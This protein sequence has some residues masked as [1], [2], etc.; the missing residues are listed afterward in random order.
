M[1]LSEHLFKNMA[2]VLPDYI[3]APPLEKAIDAAKATTNGTRS[4]MHERLVTVS[5]DP[6]TEEDVPTNCE[7]D[8]IEPTN[9]IEDVE[10]VRALERDAADTRGLRRLIALEI[11]RNPEEAS[12]LRDI[13]RDFCSAPL[14]TF[15]DEQILGAQ[16]ETAHT[17]FFT[18]LTSSHRGQG[19]LLKCLQEILKSGVPCG[20]FIRT[21]T[22]KKIAIAKF[23]HYIKECLALW[24]DDE[25]NPPHY[26]HEATIA[27]CFKDAI[28]S[29]LM[30]SMLATK[31]KDSLEVPQATTLGDQEVPVEERV[32]SH[33]STWK[34]SADIFAKSNTRLVVSIAK[35]Y[36]G[37]SLS[38][39]DLIMEGAKGLM[40]AIHR[41]EYR[42]KNKFSTYATWWI[43]Q[44][45]LRG[46]SENYHIVGTKMNAYQV[47][48]KVL[49]HNQKMHHELEREL[50][51]AEIAEST[52]IDVETIQRIIASK[53]QA[54]SL[55]APFERGGDDTG[56]GNLKDPHSH[57]ENPLRQANKKDLRDRLLTG[58]SALPPL[59]RTIINF[60]TGLGARE[61][62]SHVASAPLQFDLDRKMYGVKLTK[63]QIAFLLGTSREWIRQTVD[64]AIEKMQN[65]RNPFT[66]GLQ[67][68][69][70]AEDE[71]NKDW[72]KYREKFGSAV[73]LH[74]FKRQRQQ[75]A[76]IRRDRLIPQTDQETAK[77]IEAVATTIEMD[78]KLLIPL[79][80]IL[81]TRLA[82]ILSAAEIYTVKDLLEC[83]KRQFLEIENLGVKRIV[84]IFTQLRR[85][86]IHHADDTTSEKSVTDAS[87]TK[88]T[89]ADE[90][91]LL[92]FAN[93]I[94]MKEEHGAGVIEFVPISTEAQNEMQQMLKGITEA[95]LAKMHRRIQ[96]SIYWYAKLALRGEN[97]LKAANNDPDED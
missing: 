10:E 39:P 38:F 58:L 96:E 35:K 65:I 74:D 7:E 60:W 49:A 44:C 41:Y 68:F 75:S 26:E 52:G 51:A 85:I 24:E 54:F 88:D 64:R 93:L 25:K 4:A 77:N 86:G 50:T 27:S 45:I 17:K 13:S 32:L 56:I 12:Q 5:T 92:R 90:N 84:E 40:Q 14:L 15:E 73:S 55:D 37:R 94:T 91:L 30:M 95:D 31:C 79:H 66:V 36:R 28:F 80:Q 3:G 6:D 82:N 19:I 20:K 43:R 21:G 61:I 1:P 16:M 70:A 23:K 62:P 81:E 47:E 78:M 69:D 57:Y 67:L 33:F 76:T 59:E 48:S 34:R 83:K 9:M 2:E 72:K 22:T 46:I 53:T 63:N 18:T 29:P 87:P 11:Q 97:S 89:R 71:E 42:R 8:E